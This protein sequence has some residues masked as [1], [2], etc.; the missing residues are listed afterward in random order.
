MRVK[1][2]GRRCKYVR[3]KGVCV[4]RDYKGVGVYTAC[5]K[6]IHV[7]QGRGKGEG[8]E[9]EEGERYKDMEEESDVIQQACS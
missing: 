3:G 1:V 7:S 9:G 5:K 4:I 6:G 8:K 2:G